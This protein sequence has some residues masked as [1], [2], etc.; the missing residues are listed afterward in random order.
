[1][2]FRSPSRPALDSSKQYAVQFTRS[3]RTATWTPRD[4]SLLSF[5]ERLG[6]ALPSG[7][8]VGQCESCAVKVVSGEVTHLSGHGPDESD[9]C[10]ACQAIPATDVSIDA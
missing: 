8:R 2:A 10:L 5:A 3:R 7:C 1:E 6:I 4:G 9:M